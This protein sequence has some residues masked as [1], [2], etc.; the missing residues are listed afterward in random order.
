MTRYG[1]YPSLLAPNGVPWSEYIRSQ[2][3]RSRSVSSSTEALDSD[4][5]SFITSRIAQHARAMAASTRSL[6]TNSPVPYFQP[7]EKG[8]MSEGRLSDMGSV[9]I[10]FATD[11]QMPSRSVNIPRTVRLPD[12]MVHHP[13][14]D[15][16][17]VMTYTGLD[18]YDTLFEARHGRGALDHVSRKSEEEIASSMGITPTTLETGLMVQSMDKEKSIV[19]IEPLSQNDCVSMMTDPLTNRVVSPSS[20]I[21]GKGA[22][23]FTNMTETM[24]TML[25]QQLAMSSN[26]KEPLNDDNVTVR[27][28]MKDNPMKRT[29]GRTQSLTQKKHIP[30]YFYQSQKIIG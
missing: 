3:N 26:V 29:Q 19:G 12:G 23:I 25:D 22:M 5:A 27:I 8:H 7:I 20:E 14:A 17:R 21:I 4:H 16:D 15:S 6:P 28:P 9:D 1:I 2:E 10:V 13:V 30:T 18:D 24:L 11:M